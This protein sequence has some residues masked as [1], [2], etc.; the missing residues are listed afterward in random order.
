MATLMLMTTP[1]FTAA[2]VDWCLT[3][4]PKRRQCDV[5]YWPKADIGYCSANISF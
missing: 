5:R 1:L 4:S 3:N 2:Y